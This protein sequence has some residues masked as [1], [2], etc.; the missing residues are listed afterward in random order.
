[1]YIYPK[2]GLTIIDPVRG[3]VLPPEGREVD[4]DDIY[5]VRRLRDGDVIDTDP[6]PAKPAAKTKSATVDQSDA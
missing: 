6:A 5:W 3:D 2:P 1:M 4:A